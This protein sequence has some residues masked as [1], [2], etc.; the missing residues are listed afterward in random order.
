MESFQKTVN[1]VFRTVLCTGVVVAALAVSLCALSGLFVP[2]NNQK[3]FG[4]TN[5]EANGI[6]GE[7]EN[8]IDVLFVGDSEAYSAFSPMQMW[9]EQ[10]FTSYVCATSQQQLPY[11]N[12]LLHRATQ[13][14]KPK[15][16]VIETNTIFAPFSADEAALRTAQDLLPVFEYHD[17]WKSV[18]AADAT[19]E[20]EA[21]WTDDLKG[22]YI[23]KDVQPADAAGHMAPSSE[24]QQIPDLN[25]RYLQ[26]MIDYCREIGATP[27]LVST[28]ST[29]CWNT[30]RHNGIAEFA[31]N[32]GVDYID[33]NVE[34]TKISIDWQ[35]D[36]RD[37][38]D[39][40]NLSGAVKVSGFI[41]KYLSETYDLPDHR[42][43]KAYHLWNE[44][45]TRYES[46]LQE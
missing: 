4:M 40:M 1:R 11:G 17:R 3:A 14:Q 18:T 33:L 42:T 46:R 35:T 15:V 28:P 37:A 25:R 22:F 44:A 45:F 31:K 6:L 41:G 38:G 8:T 36:T 34:P 39:H 19:G 7:P 32:A 10:G 29:V 43:D 9:S 26:V 13:N 21:T 5:Q 27:V 30:A 2:K 16:V 24:V 23:N 20:P 12:T